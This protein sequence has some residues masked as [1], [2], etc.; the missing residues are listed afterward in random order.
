[1]EIDIEVLK[2]VYDYIIENGKIYTL[3]DYMDLND[4]E[5]ATFEDFIEYLKSNF[6]ANLQYDFDVRFSL[7][8]L[9]KEV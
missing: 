3:N 4:D 9:F 2:D 1:M 7:D 8:K 6:I 5:I